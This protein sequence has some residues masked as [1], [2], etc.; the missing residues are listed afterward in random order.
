MELIGG[1]EDEGENP[2]KTATREILEET[3]L[4]IKEKGLREIGYFRQ[5]VPVRN[6]KTKELIRLEYGLVTLFVYT[7]SL[8]KALPLHQKDEFSELLWMTVEEV[9]LRR[10]E[11]MLG[12]IRMFLE[13]YSLS[14]LDDYLHSKPIATKNLADQITFWLPEGSSK[15]IV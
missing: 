15:I 5:R 1:G 9:I 8:T 13:F 11:F 6:A 14:M 12:H 3:S 4:L 7:T 2:V 10:Q